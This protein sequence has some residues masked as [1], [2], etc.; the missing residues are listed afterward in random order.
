M[1][2]TTKI[3]VA[4]VI[5]NMAMLMRVKVDKKT[6][7]E[8][9]R[10][11]EG[12]AEFP[13]IVCFQVDGELIL[14]DGFH[15]LGAYKKNGVEKIDAD[16]RIGTL[17][18]ALMVAVR[19]NAHEGLARTNADKE[20]AVKALLASAKWRG[21]TDIQIA[22]EAAVAKSFVQKHRKASIH[23]ASEATSTD[24]SRQSRRGKD[25]KNYP[26][27]RSKPTNAAAVPTFSPAK[28]QSFPKFTH[29]QL[30]APS[31]ETANEQDPDS[32][33]GV[34][35]ALAYVQKHGH[36]HLRPLDEKLRASREKM[37]T[38]FIATLRELA[39]P[40]AELLKC[41]LEPEEI[42]AT[43]EGMRNGGST[44]AMKKFDE[45]LAVIQPLLSKL[46][47]FSAIRNTKKTAV[48]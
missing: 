16:V 45:R 1:L 48:A 33:P 38:S 27:T 20:K 36:V 30:G 6:V 47:A 41:E 25:G 24:T 2:Q 9:A 32:P 39:K 14:V 29:E 28:P 19:A 34:T 8:Y 7:T 3:D 23:L 31:P 11:M 43:I 5:A 18:E 40:A 15:R 35:R 12:G 17:D 22:N 44:V 21:L 37:V 10:A 4:E 26:A 42:I 13:P 46:N